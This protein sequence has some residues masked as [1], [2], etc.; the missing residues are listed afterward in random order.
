LPR[1]PHRALEVTDRLGDEIL[2]AY[3]GCVRGFLELGLGH[4]DRAI[5]ALDELAD[6]LG[7][8]PAA[9]PAVL[10]WTPDLIEAYVRQ[11][12]TADADAA[13]VA[14]ER[15]AERSESRWARAAAGRCRGLLADDDGFQAPFEDALGAHD[16]PFEL[17]HTE[18]CLG[19]RLRR[20]GRRVQSRVHL[21]SALAT[22]D[23]L[24]ARPWAERA[25]K[26]L[27]G[28]GERVR[29]GAPVATERLTPQEL[30]V[31]LEVARGSTNREAAAALFLSPKTIEFHLRNIYRTLSI[32]SRTEL[33]RVVM[34]D[35]GSAA[36]PRSPAKTRHLD[37][38]G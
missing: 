7:E 29:R 17:A 5:A 19:E 18:L 4:S 37:G 9:D 24:G 21:R 11:G 3:V 6:L 31:A 1:A 34:S 2:R 36:V 13:L 26:D 30:Q 25:R 20:A 27:R 16:T 35:S 22:F 32:R 28:S 14:F 10:Q 15:D 23:R 33:V 38:R 12:R 8:R